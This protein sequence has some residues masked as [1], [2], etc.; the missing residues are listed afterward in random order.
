MSKHGKQTGGPGRKRTAGLP[1]TPREIPRKASIVA[2]DTITSPKGGRYT[3]LE[4]DQMDPYD[5][6]KRKVGGQA[7]RSKSG[8]KP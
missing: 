6:P 5:D 3:I 2:V 4:T 1:R 8:G 7:T